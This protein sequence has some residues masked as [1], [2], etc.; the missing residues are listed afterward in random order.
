MAKYSF[1]QKGYEE[2]EKV[3]EETK[4]KLARVIKEKAEAGSGQD[5]WHD[6]GFKLGTVEEMMWSK[7]LGELQKLAL[8][9]EIVTPEEQNSLIK[10]GTG[11]IV[12]YEDGAFGKYIIEGYI[13]K[14]LKG[15]VSIYSPLGK[16]LLGA[17]KGEV[18]SVKIGNV[19]RT[20]TIQKILPPSKAEDIFQTNNNK[21]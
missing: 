4:V 6:E 5:T 18:R 10:I 2:L 15:R 8:N 3:I 1:T 16:S 11:V 14:A 12:E 9:A 20:V 17:K 7:K 13:I 21:Q 19:E